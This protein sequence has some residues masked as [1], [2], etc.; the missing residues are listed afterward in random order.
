MAGLS[1]QELDIIQHGRVLVSFGT[2]SDPVKFPV[3]ACTRIT[4]SSTMVDLRTIVL[5]SVA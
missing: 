4:H 2:S 3:S 1:K 5:H